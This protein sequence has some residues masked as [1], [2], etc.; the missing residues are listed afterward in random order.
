MEKDIDLLI[1]DVAKERIAT[2]QAARE[3]EAAR[4]RH[5]AAS[6]RLESAE[7]ALRQTIQGRLDEI[8]PCS[9]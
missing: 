6:D 3:L 1:A 2:R 4:D 8:D 5:T 7:I 9:E